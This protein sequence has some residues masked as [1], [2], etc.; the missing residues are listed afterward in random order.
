MLSKEKLIPM[1]ACMGLASTTAQQTSSAFCN[2]SQI[3]ASSTSTRGEACGWQPYRGSRSP[4]HHP[5][6]G[7]AETSHEKKTDNV[8]C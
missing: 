3:G 4:L 5:L 6:M 8:C 1:V 2:C 7:T